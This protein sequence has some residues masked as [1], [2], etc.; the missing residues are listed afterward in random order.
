MLTIGQSFDHSRRKSLMTLGG[1]SLGGVFLSLA[2]VLRARADDMKD[3][4]NTSIVFIWMRGGASHIET[5]NPLD[6]A[7]SEFRSMNGSIS[8][9][10]HDVRIGSLFPNIASCADN[11]AFIRSYSHEDSGHGGAI[12]WLSTGYDFSGIDQGEPQN[13]PSMGS[14]TARV[15]GTSHQK[16]GMPMYVSFPSI[17]PAPPIPPHIGFDAAWLGQ[18]CRPFSVGG[19]AQSNMVLHESIGVGRLG[20]RRDLLSG[21]DRLSRKIDENRSLDGFDAFTQQ[22]FKLITGSA[23]EAFDVSGESQKLRDAYGPDFGSQ[24]LIARRLCEAG[25]GFVCLAHSGWDM[26]D[27]LQA[28]MNTI[29][30]SFDQA[31]ATFIKDCADRALDE[32]ILLV[33][34]GEFGRTPKINSDAG[35]DHWPDVNSILLS[36]GGLKMGQCIGSTDAKGQRV[37]KDKVTPQDLIATIFHV[38]GINLDV[39]FTDQS[40]RPHLMIT[41]GKPIPHLL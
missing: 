28:R 30:P 22:A 10:L 35:R 1:L 27:D 2:D 29:T 32:N 9:S 31:I 12:H 23:R 7:P 6:E 24:L 19:E 36:G 25:C 13:K 16:T 17:Y 15:R 38:L 4:P 8:T 11:V 5:F 20:E 14:I 26:H 39:Q 21:L 18:H 37:D 41:D 33:V 40:G 34:A 3:H